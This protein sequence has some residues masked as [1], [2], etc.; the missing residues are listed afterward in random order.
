M[1]HRGLVHSSPR[2][3]YSISVFSHA[4]LV[5]FCNEFRVHKRLRREVV[6][7]VPYLGGVGGPTTRPASYR[8]CLCLASVFPKYTR[9]LD[10]EIFRK[11]IG[12]FLGTF[13]GSP[14]SSP[15]G[16]LG[17]AEGKARRTLVF[18]S[19]RGSGKFQ[20]NRQ[21]KHTP[22]LFRKIVNASTNDAQIAWNSKDR[23]NVAA[24]CSKHW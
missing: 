10:T 11:N 15:Q 23:S 21:V 6:R 4:T 17:F 2:F 5:N 19:P 12:D 7:G 3:L 24:L 22:S 20:K 13:G 8:S 14:R 18:V 1:A 16:R 9:N